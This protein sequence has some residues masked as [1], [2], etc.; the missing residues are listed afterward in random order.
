MDERV[1]KIAEELE[2]LINDMREDDLREQLKKLRHDLFKLSELLRAGV[3]F[4]VDCNGARATFETLR[5]YIYFN[6][7]DDTTLGYLRERFKQEA[8][9]KLPQLMAEAIEVLHGIVVKLQRIQ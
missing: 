1:R 2:N 5:T 9:E 8:M 7:T 3:E 6:F 4:Y